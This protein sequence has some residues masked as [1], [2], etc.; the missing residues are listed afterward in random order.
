MKNNH[1]EIQKKNTRLKRW[2][3]VL[4]GA[5]IGL[6]IF[7]AV[8]QIMESKSSQAPATSTEPSIRIVSTSSSQAAVTETSSMDSTTTTVTSES[9][10]EPV[11]PTA[12][13]V[14]FSK[15]AVLIGENDQFKFSVTTYTQND[16]LV[17][18]YGPNGYIPSDAHMNEVAAFVPITSPET[19]IQTN[20]GGV[21]KTVKVITEL[22]LS[23]GEGS[24]PSLE[25]FTPFNGNDTKIY[26]YLND[27]GNIV[28]AFTPAGH[29]GAYTAISL[30]EK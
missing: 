24:K 14:T 18:S 10:S 12:H 30:Q 5:V 9:S 8:T 20:E 15:G 19:T 16:E 22:K 1:D 25:F 3:I 2:L 21:I 13:P 11:E 28:L 17:I 7:I 4:S 29:S 23:V 26:A 6:I 27:R